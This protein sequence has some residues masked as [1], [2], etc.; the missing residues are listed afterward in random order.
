LKTLILKKKL[1]VLQGE[2]Y[3]ITES[4]TLYEHNISKYN[5]S[6]QLLGFVLLIFLFVI[7]LGNFLL[8]CIV[9][10]EKFGMDSQKRTVTNQLLSSICWNQII[11]NC[12]FLTSYTINILGIQSKTIFDTG[13]KSRWPIRAK[14]RTRSSKLRHYTKKIFHHTQTYCA[15]DLG[16]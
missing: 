11:F 7:T 13:S 14:L 4:F 5:F 8:F 16:V 15:G 10:Y 2:Y 6:P 3:Q 9:V 1:P 12:T